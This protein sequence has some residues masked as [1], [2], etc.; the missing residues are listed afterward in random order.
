LHGFAGFYFFDGMHPALDLFRMEESE[1]MITPAQY[2]FE[3]HPEAEEAVLLAM[4][5][6]LNAAFGRALFASVEGDTLIVQCGGK[7][8]RIAADG[9]LA[10]EFSTGQSGAS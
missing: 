9:S 8:A 5:A 6:S 7:T 1:P 3:W 2:G 4:A 10:G